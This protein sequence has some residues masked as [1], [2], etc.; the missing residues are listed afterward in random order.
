MYLMTSSNSFS[1]DKAQASFALFSLIH[2]FDIRPIR[3]RSI[4]HKQA[5]LYSH[6]F[7]YLTFVQFVLAR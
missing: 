4:K 2:V 7:T 5:L 3:S 6:L 1:L